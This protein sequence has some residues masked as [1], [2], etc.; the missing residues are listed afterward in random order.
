MAYK[1]FS[2]V[3]NSSI[4]K[5]K[6]NAK[7]YSFWSKRLN[8]SIFQAVT[9]LG[10]SR[11]TTLDEISLGEIQK[12]FVHKMEQARMCQLVTPV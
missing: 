11:G 7:K 10:F 6:K 9:I 8:R 5:L 3:D 12:N 4:V 2:F 1:D